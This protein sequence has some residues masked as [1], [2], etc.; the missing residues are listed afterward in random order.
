MVYTKQTWADAPAATSP[1]SAAR[2]THM[3]DGIEEASDRITPLEIAPP[4]HTH[5]TGQVVGFTAAVD[6]R[7]AI[8]TAA[9]VDSAPGTLDTL[10]EL[11]AALGDDPNFATTLAG[12]IAAKQPLDADLTAIAALAPANDSIIQRKG[13]VWTSRTVAQFA[14]DLGIV[15]SPAP[16]APLFN[17]EAHGAV[18]D[19][20]TDNYAAFLA[21]WNAM[22]AFSVGGVLFGPSIGVYRC[23][24]NPSRI[25]E[26]TDQQYAAF[27]IPLRAR[28]TTKLTYGIRGVG[29]AYTVR[30]AELGGTPGQVATATVFR[31]D[32]TVADFAWSPT[33]GLPSVFG[34]VDADMTDFEG[35]TFSNVHFTIDDVIL[36]NMPNPSVCL[37]N[38][39]Q[40][41][42]C[43]I[44]RVRFD[45]NAVLDQ[46][47]EPTHPTG[48][49]LLLP[50]SNNNVA[51]QVD[52][53]IVEGH[54]AG[55]PLTEH[56]ELRSAIVLRCKIGIPVRRPCS[57]YGFA[58]HL[59][60]EQCQFGFA[61]YD[62]SGAAPNLGVVAH[63]GWTGHI[64]FVDVEDYA[65]N[66][67]TPWIYTPVY[68][69]HIYDPQNRFSGTISFWG[70]INSE[71]AS[72][73]GIGV[74]PGGGGSTLYVI[75][76]AGTNSPIAVYGFNHTVGA[77]RILGTA[78]ANPVTDPPNAPTI[79]VATGGVESAS[80]TFTPPVSG[81]TPTSYL[82]TSSPGGLTGTGSSSPVTV[83]G[84]TGGQAYTFTVRAVNV[85]GNSPASAASNSVTPSAGGGGFPADTFTGS[86]ATELG[87][88]S[89]GHTWLGDG[90][91]TW[92]RQ[93]NK[94]VAVT[95]GTL[96]N[97][98]WVEV[99][100]ANFS[101]KADITHRESERGICARLV[102]ASN[103]LYLDYQWD[104]ANTANGQLYKRVAGSLTAMGSGFVV[105]GLTADQP[106]RLKIKCDG[107]QITA[108]VNK[109]IGVD[110]Q[111]AQVT[112]AT[113]N[114]ATKAG[115][116]SLV[117]TA[118]NPNWD[119][120][121]TEAV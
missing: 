40:V 95:V 21:A 35:N 103:F 120:F 12:Q 53:I 11:A 3:E 99:G 102:D 70:R 80:V 87:V 89:S 96:M 106:V 37:V 59:K 19:G 51:V 117:S 85:V 36:R 113:F 71:S 10:N 64:T 39:E 104:S 9:L 88:S 34:C 93:G 15:L 56:I 101:V 92:E 48:A 110:T 16:Y 97:P 5:T 84:L 121:L 31:F 75:G 72:P 90:A 76:A 30:A 98:V 114:T 60:I 27:P 79:G 4:A 14:A 109:V 50:R 25:T 23:V 1:L 73:P 52:S 46:V 2:L 91:N 29:E 41:S 111:V 18:A 17:I 55:V 26:R 115:M 7:V 57:H 44:G 118:V 67:D 81:P 112:D 108:Y 74:G 61:G 47:P 24:L 100:T 65:Y 116:V 49:A 68:G 6:A 66:G 8:G 119:D 62:P 38:I 86:D 13:G 22:L 94:A 63:P 43:R 78:P 32:Y 69:C 20:T 83:G 82:A 77:T 33:S 107:D 54:Y 28:T 105:S 45:V 42:T 58:Q